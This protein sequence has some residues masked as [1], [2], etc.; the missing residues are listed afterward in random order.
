MVAE[1]KVAKNRLHIDVRMGRGPDA[2][3]RIL[4]KVAE[5][6]AAGGSVLATAEA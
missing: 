2:W 4:A 3:Q 5:L 6:V 1:P